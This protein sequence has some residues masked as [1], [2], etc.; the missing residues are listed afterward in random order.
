LR[1]LTTGTG[2][3]VAA[4]VWLWRAATRTADTAA[5]P[6]TRAPIPAA[7][8]P[9]AEI[10]TQVSGPDAWAA[11]GEDTTG[12][13]KVPVGDGLVTAPEEP[14]AELASQIVKPRRNANTTTHPMLI[15]RL[16]VTTAEVI[17]ETYS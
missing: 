11:G 10:T 12:D 16:R 6:L 15:A 2:A 4:A 14:F 7:A 13:P 8:V 5:A 17:A 1:F 9:S 3:A